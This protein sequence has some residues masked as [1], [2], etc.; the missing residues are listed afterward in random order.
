[1]SVVRSADPFI[2]YDYS[3]F[4]VQSVELQEPISC[5]VKAR[6]ILD[7]LAVKTVLLVQLQPVQPYIVYNNMHNRKC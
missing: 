2:H 1:M 7:S 4:P 6:F 3:L 5:T